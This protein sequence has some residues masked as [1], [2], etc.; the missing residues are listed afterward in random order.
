MSDFNKPLCSLFAALLVLA[1]L[2]GCTPEGTP[3]AISST[4][5]FPTTT[6]QAYEYTKSNITYLVPNVSTTYA[7]KDALITTTTDGDFSAF[8][9]DTAQADD[10]VR[11]QQ[12]L[13][14][15]LRQQ[16]VQFGE[17]KYF[18]MD[19]GY[20][21]SNDGAAY[22]SLSQLYS[23][24]QVLVT[25]QA[26][27]GD[28]ID[29]GYVYAL[30]NAV[31]EELG[32]ATD[33][34]PEIQQAALDAFF[35]VNPDTV[36]LLY[37]V[38]TT[39][40]ASEEAVNCCKSLSRSLLDQLDWCNMMAKPIE[41]QLDDWYALIGEYAQKIGVSFSRQTIQYAY[42]GEAVQLRI[43]MTYAEL[44]IDKNF[45]DQLAY[46]YGD[47]W[48][49][50]S[51]IYQTANIINDE[52]VASVEY[53]D[54][55]DKISMLALNFI[56]SGHPSAKALTAGHRGAYYASTQTS[57]VTTINSYLHEY[58]H[59]IEYT[60]SGDNPRTWQSQAFCDLGRSYS[61][62]TLFAF[63]YDFTYLEDGYEL[64]Y[65]Y[66]GRTYESGRRD[67]YEVFDI[68]CHVNNY[69]KFEYQ[70]GAQTHNSFTRYLSELYGEDSVFDLL[71][72]PDTIETVTGKTWKTLA[73]EWEQ[74][75]REKYA[76]V[77]IP[78]ALLQT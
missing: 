40:F 78:V 15:Y 51:S 60:I 74:A 19:Y 32:W 69:Y 62:H 50:Y 68:L 7:S 26:I 30:S 18:G 63:Q 71:L 16:G 45:A 25:L 20:S 77:V 65:T 35:T 52:I 56:D 70:T 48:G 9:A 64:F 53:F 39:A 72:H 59:H 33:A 76:D 6:L 11:S 5:A 23:W 43:L 67:Y 49:T 3:S 1:L 13:L 66:T 57:Y 28:Y 58:Y 21:F 75:I 22:V 55:E 10:F 44:I 14:T 31:A 4:Q 8:T 29:Y 73:A 38:F 27:W 34:Q 42:F 36:N 41:D 2:A 47:Y 54:L 61:Y 37:P 24:Q 17:R 12:A 46:I